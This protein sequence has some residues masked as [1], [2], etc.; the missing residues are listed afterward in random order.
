MKVFIRGHAEPVEADQPVPPLSPFSLFVTTTPIPRADAGATSG[1]GGAATVPAATLTMADWSPAGASPPSLA[2]VSVPVASAITEV[3]STTIARSGLGESSEA[4]GGGIARGSDM[5]AS[6]AL[7]GPG[8]EDHGWF[9]VP[10]ASN[11]YGSA[12]AAAGDFAFDV[13]AGEFSAEWFFWA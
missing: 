13:A 2:S 9:I 3:P 7:D 11:E 1:Q 12:Y 4:G 8:Y 5:L 6:L 10:S